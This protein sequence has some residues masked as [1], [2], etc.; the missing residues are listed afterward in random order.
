MTHGIR[1]ILLAGAAAAW[2]AAVIGCKQ[3]ERSA[4]EPKPES[5][6]AVPVIATEPTH[7][8]QP[9]TPPSTQPTTNPTGETPTVPARQAKSLYEPDNNHRVETTV[10]KPDDEQA[11]WLR[12]EAL[13]DPNEAASVSG[14]FPRPNVMIVQSNNVETLSIDLDM[15]PLAAARRRI[16]RIDDQPF[17][18]SQRHKG[19]I[20]L[21]HSAAGVWTV[22]T[23]PPSGP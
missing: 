15:L 11:G 4:P 17:E 12:I 8:A 10:S 13:A 2:I 1:R 9:T 22:V 7:P 14:E 20:V 19:R 18:L 16:L 21:K 3:A 23:A 6:P 5:K